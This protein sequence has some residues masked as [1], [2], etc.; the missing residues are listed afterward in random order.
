LSILGIS[1]K[2]NPEQQE[3]VRLINEK[4]KHIIFCE[5]PAGSGKNFATIAAAL[6]LVREKKYKH[7]IYT[8][9]AIQ[10]GES[11]G[12]I[13]GDA[14]EK[15]EPFLAPLRDTIHSIC[16]K[17]EDNL[18]EAML[19]DQ[20]EVMPLVFMRGRNIGDDTIC[21]VDEA[22][23]C[24]VSVLNALITRGSE[25]SKIIIIG[26]IRQ[27]DDDRIARKSKCDFQKV[28]EALQELPYVGYVKLFRPMRSPWCVEVDEILSTL[29]RYEREDEQ[30]EYEHRR[31]S[32]THQATIGDGHDN[33]QITWLDP[34]DK[35]KDPQE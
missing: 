9:N 19:L 31:Q 21:I 23:N 7:I 5:G 17:S 32:H 13:K 1:I 11:I 24:P 34:E 6:Q 3:L 22:Q 8:R 18:N 28:I 30:R 35:K 2:N 29:E 33:I 16:Q 26:S 14:D 10:L 4:N 27:I 15:M 25:F 20:F 12:F